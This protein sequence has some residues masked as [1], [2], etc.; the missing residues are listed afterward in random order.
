MTK[1]ERNNLALKAL[2]ELMVKAEGQRFRFE[3]D[4]VSLLGIILQL[5]LA[6]RSPGNVGR[7]Q[8]SARSFLNQI[9]DKYAEPGGP[10]YTL[11][12]SEEHQT[13]SIDAPHES[14]AS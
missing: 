12:Q 2:G 1:E 11:M 3:F 10:L 4:A 5:Q 9:R 14:E 8:V 7:A 6:M 13:E